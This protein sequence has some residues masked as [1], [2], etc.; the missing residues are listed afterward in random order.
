MRTYPDC[1]PCFL[2]QALGPVADD[3]GCNE[4]DLVLTRTRAN[5]P[6]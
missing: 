6:S 5:T 2:R 3:V 1:V 4:G